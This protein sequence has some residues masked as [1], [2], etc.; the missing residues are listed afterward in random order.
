M[1]AVIIDDEKNAVLAL[2]NDL[3]EHCPEVQV[4]ASFTRAAEALEFLKCNPT[5]VV[6]LDIEMPIL[7]G[8]DFIKAID[9][10]PK[11]QL[12]FVTAYSEFAI[13]AFKVNAIDYL[14]K[15]VI[16]E[17]LKAAVAK[18]AQNTNKSQELLLRNFADNQHHAQPKKVVFSTDEGY[19][20]V[21]IN[22]IIY[23][24]ANGAYTEIILLD[25]RRILISKTLARVQE[26]VPVQHFERIH[27]SYMVNIAHIRNFKKG[28]SPMVVMQNNDVLKVS[29]MKKEELAN[30]LGVAKTS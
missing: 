15:P 7:N 16:V 25:N 11:F 3:A 23:L 10:T 26:V 22:E 18:A 28:D 20:F 12:I 19:H 5:D 8:F 29:R 6:F 9:Y 24:K 14:L 17:E 4:I 21:E 30:R 27:Q 13:N 1:N 2:A